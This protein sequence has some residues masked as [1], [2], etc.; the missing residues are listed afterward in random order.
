[1]AGP[2][3][4]PIP[5]SSRPTPPNHPHPPD[6]LPSAGVSTSDV[7]SAP[8]GLGIAGFKSSAPANPSVMDQF[9]TPGSKLTG[10]EQLMIS[11]GVR[12]AY[13]GSGPAVM[14]QGEY[15]SHVGNNR[16]NC[17]CSK[18]EEKRSNSSHSM[19]AQ[20]G[21][22]S[23]DATVLASLHEPVTPLEKSCNRWV[24]STQRAAVET[25][26][27]KIVMGKVRALL[28]KLT[29][30]KFDSISDQIIAWTNK[31]KDGRTLNQVIGLIFEKAIDEPKR[32]EMYALLC[33]TMM[34]GISPEIRDNDVKTWDGGRIISGKLLRK[35]LLSR[36]QENFDYG[37]VSK[38]ATGRAAA[39]N[40]QKKNA[41]ELFDEYFASQE[42]G[43][44][45]LSLIKF[46][47]ELFKLHMLTERIVHEC[48]KKLGNVE[49][50][51]EEVLEGLCQL[52]R[53]CGSLLDVPRTRAQTD[54]YFA[55]MKELS[56]S[57]N[58]SPRVQ[59]MLQV[60]P[61]ILLLLFL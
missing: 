36:C 26:T 5:A 21:P 48:V 41:N 52:L 6:C 13:V 10:E 17:T 40:E 42:A 60:V 20:Q 56:N 57:G 27:L 38:E 14:F 22:S 34:M 8:V 7:W 12:S 39:A 47:G 29:I 9:H 53:T 24:P 32:S 51:D 30:K 35:Y 23:P 58:V 2:G 11:S 19:L 3:G 15:G 54:V 50:P 45:G 49:N 18:R 46:M 43:H 25:D 16:R 31:S 44:R 61:G 28:S 33:H 4:L 37:W 59:F 1:M 55:R